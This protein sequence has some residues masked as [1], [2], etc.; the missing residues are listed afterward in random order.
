MFTVYGQIHRFLVLACMCVCEWKRMHP[1]DQKAAAPGLF[2]YVSLYCK[3]Q[4][5]KNKLA[6]QDK[7]SVSTPALCFLWET[8]IENERWGRT[9]FWDLWRLKYCRVTAYSLVCWTWAL[10]C[11]SSPPAA[12]R[13]SSTAALSHTTLQRLHRLHM[14][15]E[16]QHKGKQDSITARKN[17]RE[18]KIEIREKWEIENIVV[19][20]Q[21]YSSCS[22]CLDKILI[23]LYT[24]FNKQ[25]ILVKNTH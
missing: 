16:T 12:L 10:L 25:F 2:A 21:A 9:G 19:D 4:Q 6:A 11:P 1:G 18:N 17:E 24:V 22:C 3:T 13:P 15:R 7:G 8:K 5:N 20:L 23:C 14:K